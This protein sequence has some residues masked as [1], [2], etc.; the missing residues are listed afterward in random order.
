MHDVRLPL[1][2]IEWIAVTRAALGF[3]VGLLASGYLPR[4]QRR[5]IGWTLV[6]FGGLSTFPLRADVMRRRMPLLRPH[7]EPSLATL[8][9]D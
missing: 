2:E 9:R 6:A 7:D 4:R 5:W 1:R 8:V 3:G